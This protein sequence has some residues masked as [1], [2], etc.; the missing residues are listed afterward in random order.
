M[1]GVD[2]EKKVLSVFD[3]T[4][5]FEVLGLALGQKALKETALWCREAKRYEAWKTYIL[6]RDTK[7]VET[8]YGTFETEVLPDILWTTQSMGKMHSYWVASP[9]LEALLHQELETYAQRG[10]DF[11]HLFKKTVHLSSVDSGNRLHLLRGISQHL[12]EQKDLYP[13]LKKQID[14]CFYVLDYEEFFASSESIQRKYALLLKDFP[15]Y[16]LKILGLGQ[17]LSE[18]EKDEFLENK[19]LPKAVEAKLKEIE[20]VFSSHI[21][22]VEVDGEYV[23][24]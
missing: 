7:V 20:A 18:S 10:F 8:P 2:F 17:A 5:G 15:C 21:R 14:L 22:T 4:R 6:S 24:V 11:R 19:S 16:E 1:T 23:E 9:E 13:S 3:T 12:I